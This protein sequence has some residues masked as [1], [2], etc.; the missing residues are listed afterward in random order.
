MIPGRIAETFAR[1]LDTSE[2]SPAAVMLAETLAESGHVTG[3]GGVVIQLLPGV[4]NAQADA[5]ERQVHRFGSLS[6]ALTRAD[7][8]PHAW[9]ERLFPQGFEVLAETQLRFLCGC[10]TERVEQA[11]LLLGADEIRSL[12]QQQQS[13]QPVSLICGFCRRRYSVPKRRLV[14]LLLELTE[15][16]VCP[17]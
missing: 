5:L 8:A 6:E 16:P 15:E 12:L 1:Y 9:L 17:Q 14:H 10:S 13:G 2:Q 4:S 3:A 7:S 11:L